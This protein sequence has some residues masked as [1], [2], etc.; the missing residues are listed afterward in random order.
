[1]AEEEIGSTGRFQ[2]YNTNDFAS[3]SGP[4]VSRQ[5]AA[6]VRPSAGTTTAAPTATVADAAAK[7][8]AAS[9][10]TVPGTTAAAT[11]NANRPTNSAPVQASLLSDTE[12]AAR[13]PTTQEVQA[14]VDQA[15]LNLK[16][17]G[18]VLDYKVD[19]ATGIAVA[20]I[21]NSQTGAV[22][23]QIPGADVLKLAKMLADWSP[24][25]HMLLDLIA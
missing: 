24:G 23:Q 6:S 25:K 15:N 2:A 4:T 21:R 14:A 8:A 18:R 11:A 10:E 3:Y 19:E 20:V 22:V 9:I 5:A 7:V 17:A 1:M 12:S 16:S 13:T